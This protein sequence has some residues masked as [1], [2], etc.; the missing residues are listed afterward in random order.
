LSLYRIGC[1]THEGL[2][3]LLLLPYLRP[4]LKWYL[5]LVLGF[6]VVVFE[7]N[8]RTLGLSAK[9]TMKFCIL[10][11]V[12]LLFCLSRCWW[13]PGYS[14]SLPGRKL[15]EYSRFLWVQVSCWSQTEWGN[16]KMWW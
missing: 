5:R 16:T 3:Q 14:W 2:S 12:I 13:V 8:F 9:V 11:Q 10:G 7:N 15:H 1:N 4:V 6:A